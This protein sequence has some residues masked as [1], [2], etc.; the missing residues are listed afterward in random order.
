MK[1]AAQRAAG[2]ASQLVSIL[3]PLRKHAERSGLNRDR[4]L[5]NRAVGTALQTNSYSNTPSMSL[6]ARAMALHAEPRCAPPLSTLCESVKEI[7]VGH[8]RLTKQIHRHASPAS[9]RRYFR[10]LPAFPALP[11]LPLPFTV[12]LLPPPH[13]HFPHMVPFLSSRGRKG[14]A[15]IILYTTPPAVQKK[16]NPEP[17]KALTPG[18]WRRSKRDWATPPPRRGAPAESLGS[19]LRLGCDA[20]T[21]RPLRADGCTQQPVAEVVVRP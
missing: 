17:A 2:P 10:P 20:E 1:P 11:R 13:P 14:H 21:D 3:W 4:N 5:R 8:Q 9:V 18:T 15:P 7:L 6:R 12:F 16:R 19:S